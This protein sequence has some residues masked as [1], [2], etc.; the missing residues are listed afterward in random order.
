MANEIVEL[1]TL[2][3]MLSNGIVLC[4]HFVLY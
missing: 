4:F 2:L 3:Q 1:S